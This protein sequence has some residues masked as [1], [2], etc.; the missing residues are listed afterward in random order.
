MEL[1]PELIV[2]TYQAA[3]IY[4]LFKKKSLN[5]RNNGIAFYSLNCDIIRRAV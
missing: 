1:R 4:Y 5:L 3:E 2:T